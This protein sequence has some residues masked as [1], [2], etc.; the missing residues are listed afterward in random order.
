MN[1][2]SR[3]FLGLLIFLTIGMSGCNDN[4]ANRTSEKHQIQTGIFLDNEVTGMN[5]KTETQSGITGSK[6]EFQYILGETIT[7]SLGGVNLP[8][9]L[10]KNIITPL[11]LVGTADTNNTEVINI[12][13]FLLSLDEDGDA[14][15]GIQVAEAAHR[16][17][18]SMTIDF[19]SNTFNVDVAELIANSGS[20]NKLLIDGT[21]AKAHIEQTIGNIET[22]PDIFTSYWL[23]GK[24]LYSVRYDTIEGAVVEQQEFN[25]GATEVTKSGILNSNINEVISVAVNINGM[26]YENNKGNQGRV[27]ACESNEQYVKTHALSNGLFDSVDLLFFDVTQA[28]EFAETL[29]ETIPRCSF[30]LN[31]KVSNNAPVAVTDEVTANEDTTIS[32]S[33]LDNDSDKDGDTITIDSAIASNGTA[34]IINGNTLNYTANVN[35]NG[36]DTIVYIISDGNGG[37]ASSVVAVTITAVNDNPVANPDSATVAEDTLINL[38]V[39][40]NDTDVDGNTITIDNNSISANNGTVSIESDSTINYTPNINFNGLDSLTYSISDGEGGAASSSVALTV[41]AVNDAP[42]AAADSVSA[43]EDTLVNIDILSNDFDPD[44]D[45]LF[46]TVATASNGAVTIKADKTLDYIPNPNFNG[47]DT[48]SYSISNGHLTDKSEVAVSITAVNDAPTISP[49]TTSIDENSANSTSVTSVSASDVDTGDTLTYSIVYNS[50]SIFGI[51]RS[52]GELSI[53]DNSLLNFE[54]STRHEVT[55]RVQDDGGLS[56]VAVVTID[57]TNVVEN[58]TPTLDITFG[59]VGTAGSNSFAT[60]RFDQPRASVI[61]RSGK[62]VVVGKNDF[63][64]ATTD[65]FIARF[66]T[67]GT[68]DR[69]F[70]HKGVVNQDFNAGAEEEAVA[71]MIDSLNRIV[72]VG[73]QLSSWHTSV[74]AARFTTTGILDTSFNSLGYSVYYDFIT[75]TDALLDGSDNILVS[76][77]DI[78]GD[79][80]LMK[81]HRDGFTTSI[82]QVDFFGAIDTAHAIVMQSDGKVLLIGTS[83]TYPSLNDFAVARFDVSSSPFLDT[84]YNGD[85]KASFDFGN[86]TDDFAFAAHINSKDEIIIT[87]STVT[88]PS[89]RADFATLKIDHNGELISDFGSGGYIIEDIDGA[90]SNQSVG[91]V[92]TEDSAGNLYFAINKGLSN[93]DSVIYKTDNL[94]TAIPS[95]GAA[96]Q[97][98]FTRNNQNNSSED[99]LIDS[100]N[101]AVLLTTTTT[102]VE[103]DL[104][105]A[106][107]TTA[108][109]PDSTFSGDGF[110]TLD[111]T[112]SVDS[113]NEMIELTVAPHAGKFVAVGTAGEGAGSKLIV[114]RYNADG[115]IDET[116]GINGYYLHTGEETSIT[117]QDIVEQSDGKLVAVGSFDADGLVVRILTTGVLD[118]SFNGSG[119]KR[120]T[121]D[122]AAVSLNAIAI[123]RNTKLVVAGSSDKN[124]GNVYMARLNLDGS[125]DTNTDADPALFFNSDKGYIDRNLGKSEKIYDIATLSD[126]SII[127]VGQKD[128]NGLV[129]KILENGSL[130]SAGFAP[131]D[132]YLSLDLSPD[133][134]SNVDTLKRV[135]IKSDGQIVAAGYSV[136]GV[137]SSVVVQLNSNGST[138]FVNDGIVS[139]HYGSN[140]E[141]KG[142]KIFALALDASERIVISGFNSND[143]NKGI[144]IA[145]ITATGVKDPLFNSADGGIVFDYEG[146][147]SASAII[148][149]SDGTIVIAGSDNLNL[150]PSDFFF[151]QKYNLVEP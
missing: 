85:G 63:T 139:H 143:S 16:F 30:D 33:V 6:G 20:S 10:A 92:V 117:G 136:G 17:A 60:D 126:G 138:L 135:K 141:S 9:A 39:L 122:S 115:S 42:I 26:L 7:F 71:V 129:I 145:R 125:F 137:A 34:S 88:P 76:A 140:D 107:F 146:D 61:D 28:L 96:G 74:F 64:G 31:I 150:F 109:I 147:E 2:T 108:G 131:S 97:A 89:S 79:F 149:R 144:F 32:I 65:I 67:D 81:F 54:S 46:V 119:L 132:G 142:A 112:F 105:V 36:A 8:A 3:L 151:L 58:A 68:L 35:F 82:G 87:G 18:D 93:V 106:R 48:I 148:V 50:N 23:S 94:G 44:G 24:T 66:N 29:T 134:A 86:E 59:I 57:V 70:G 111:T 25:V 121:L 52:T 49:L 77:N 43:N 15:N 78:A 45:T 75:A 124:E 133:L 120:L 102:N 14:S 56:N 4:S 84:S 98:T 90:G 80:T 103:P 19:N 69:T 95:Y 100:S 110:S 127:A 62:L 12:V 21:T 41:T 118:A 91:R 123:D 38:N 27:V 13:R 114:S 5:Y 51:N 55:V 116:F 104:V 37:S 83:F 113:L 22:A 47:S 101:R 40:T 73:N 130:D 53:A 1:S 99:L 72:I 128:I 11:G